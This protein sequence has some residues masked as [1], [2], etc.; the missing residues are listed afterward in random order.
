MK[1]A[2]QSAGILLGIVAGCALLALGIIAAGQ[3]I[4]RHTTDKA[5]RISKLQREMRG[6][7]AENHRQRSWIILLER[8]ISCLEQ[9]Q[10][11]LLG[12]ACREK[13]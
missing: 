7:Q 9:G 6:V 5:E 1:C 3:Y 2:L 12:V 8:R 13:P 4:D 11:S 10:T